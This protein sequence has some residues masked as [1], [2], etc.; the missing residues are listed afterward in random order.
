MNQ[1]WQSLKDNFWP[2]SAI[3]LCPCHLPLS[4][5]GIAMLTAGTAFGAFLT[6]HYST[7]ESVLAVTF[8]FY[9]VMAFMIW[10]V[11]GPK[12]REGAAC[13]IDTDGSRKLSGLSTKN[14]IV[15]GIIGMFVVPALVSVSVFVQIDFFSAEVLQTI[16]TNTDYNS[17][18]IWLFSLTVVVMIPVMVIWLVW[19]WLAWLKTDR[20]DPTLDWGYDYE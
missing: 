8:S 7:I 15:W 14:I 17:G 1:V 6:T 10:V 11:R 16:A 3:L 20:D 5:T 2:V 19:L 18:L 9:F 4:M 13:V 12:Q